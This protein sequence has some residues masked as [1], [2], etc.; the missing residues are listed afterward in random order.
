[1]KAL[2]LITWISFQT[3]ASFYQIEFDSMEKCE[4]ARDKIVLRGDR[5][6]TDSQRLFLNSKPTQIPN[7]L[8]SFMSAVCIDR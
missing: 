4:K 7:I 3:P 5:D 2:L 6:I 1:M 8:P